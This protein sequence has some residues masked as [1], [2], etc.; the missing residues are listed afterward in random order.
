M[1]FA[2]CCVLHRHNFVLKPITRNQLPRYTVTPNAILIQLKVLQIEYYPV[3]ATNE[4]SDL[5]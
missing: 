3:K 1:I 5:S 2:K 4:T